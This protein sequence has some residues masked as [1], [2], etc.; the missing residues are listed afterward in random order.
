[1]S[2]ARD[3]FTNPMAFI[4]TEDTPQC[5]SK[6]TPIEFISPDGNVADADG[7]ESQ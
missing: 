1:M 7:S 4:A 6:I 2:L 3:F 5:L